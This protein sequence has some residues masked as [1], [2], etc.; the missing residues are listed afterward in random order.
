VI[1]Q[2]LQ[3]VLEYREEDVVLDNVYN[4]QDKFVNLPAACLGLEIL[5]QIIEAGFVNDRNEDDNIYKEKL[6]GDE[7]FKIKE[8]CE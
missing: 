8:I 3:S 2:L 1:E 5:G 4:F 6:N 7:L